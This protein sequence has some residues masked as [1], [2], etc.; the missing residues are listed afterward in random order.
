MWV[1]PD[2]PTDPV[3]EVWWDPDEPIG[4]GIDFSVEPI[5]VARYGHTRTDVI[6]A[7]N[8]AEAR[9]EGTVVYFPAGVYELSTGL[10]LSGY[11]CQLRGDGAT[12]T[13]TNPT[14]TVLK[15]STQSG[16]VLDYTGWVRPESFQGRTIHGGFHV[17][18]SGVA[19]PTRNNSGVRLTAMSSATF[20]DISVRKTGGPCWEHASAPGGGVYLCDFER[21]VLTTPTGAKANDVAYAIMD[22]SNG[23]RFR[24]WGI[25]GTSTPEVGVSGAV[26]LKGNATFSPHDNL[27]DG[28][29]IES[30]ALPTGATIFHFAANATMINNFQFF[31]VYKEA[32]ATGTSHFRFVP[33][34][35]NDYGGNLLTGVI[36]GRDPTPPTSVDMGVDMRQS[37][38]SIRGVK[39]YRGTNVTLAVGVTNTDIE[40]GGAF[41]GGTDPAVVDSSASATNRYV[42]HQL[43]TET[44]GAW[45]RDE[46]VGGIRFLSQANAANAN[47][48]L[49]NASV[50]FVANSTTLF[51]WANTLTLRNVANTSAPRIYFGTGN[52]FPGL[53]VGNGTPNSAVSA[54]IGSLYLQRDG[55]AGTTLWVKES[56][57][58]T[59]T[60]WVAK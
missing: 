39:G 43:R 34:T 3:V 26:I 47:L 56:G 60:G 58:G 48:W 7:L 32:A 22:E 19:D 51:A 35:V 16:P 36:P 2:A 45:R 21:I 1:G 17:V 12:G 52:T 50:G 54:Q 23:N 5:N 37:R 4:A 31:D 46:S 6:E 53:D 24:G 44:Q 29:W 10:S 30:L 27:F 28:W 13:L 14:G 25:R 59:N 38:N 33:P 57:A 18:G 15:A 41:A 9:G 55:G 40:L 20:T 11:S 8:D 49:G 42:D